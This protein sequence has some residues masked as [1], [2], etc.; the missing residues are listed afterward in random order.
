MTPITFPVATTERL[1]V[2]ELKKSDREQIFELFSDPVVTAHYDIESFLDI[3]EADNF[4]EFFTTESQENGSL[5]WAMRLKGE[6]GLI[7]TCG[8]N[9]ID[10]YDGCATVGLDLSPKYWD[11]GFA[12]EGFG[13]ILDFAFSPR[14]PFRMNRIE[15]LVMTTNS[16]SIAVT[17]KAGFK[18]EGILRERSFSKGIFHDMKLFSLIR[19][20]HEAQ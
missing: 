13:A 19:R 5:R 12:R 6:S 15:V 9:S 1:V 20:D 10:P 18:F 16:A 14:F 2:D 8:F 4:I 7:G 17:E 3:K 11:K